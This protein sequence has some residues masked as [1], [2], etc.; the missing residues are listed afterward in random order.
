VRAGAISLLAVAVGIP[1]AAGAAAQPFVIGKTATPATKV[2]AQSSA[3]AKRIP[4]AKVVHHTKAK[5]AT[6]VTTTAPK[7]VVTA[8][9]P[10]APPTTQYVAPKP[11]YVPPTTQP[12]V[13][14]K[15]K[16]TPPP[17]P[18]VAQQGSGRCGGNLPPCYVMMRE[19]KG[20]LTAKNPS[21][22]ASGKW[23]FLNSTW[24][25][26]G[27][28]PTAASAPESVQDARAAQVW[29]GGAG[30]SNWSAC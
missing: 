12:Y 9:P 2:S 15:P 25:G 11:K 29:A 3:L 27:G 21:S 17:Q 6:P 28:Y 22:T 8:P 13:A 20:S 16:Y 26:Y 18:Y 24:Q 5:P 10:T 23:Q 19:S 1:L 14:P 30:C 7:P 4:K